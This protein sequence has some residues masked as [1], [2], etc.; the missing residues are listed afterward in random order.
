MTLPTSGTITLAMMAAE[1]VVPGPPYYLSQFYR[2]GTYV[3]NTGANAGI[4][5]SGTLTIPTHFYG[6]QAF[7]PVTHI[8][9]AHGSFTETI[10][11]GASS[12]VIEVWGA[13][14]GGGNGSGT[15][16]NVKGGGGGG[17]G[18]Y[19]RSSSMSVLGHSGQTMAY[20]VGTGGSSGSSGVASTV[21][22]GTFTIASTLNG[23]GGAGGGV[24]TGGL[25]GAGGS[26]SGG[27]VNTIGN[28]GDSGGLGNLGGNGG[29]AVTGVYGT[30]TRGGHGGYTISNSGW[31]A[32]NDGVV[33]F[34]YT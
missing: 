5:T 20:T 9:S 22:S 6:G 34:Y 19:S 14:G 13:T 31:T 16:C 27:S 30:G 24:G 2:G 25:G 32:G 12:V 3:P 15:G 7:S 8:Y 33:V 17:S 1:F 23:G 11:A 10:P 18:G 29:L 21:S 26:A 28:T 4:P